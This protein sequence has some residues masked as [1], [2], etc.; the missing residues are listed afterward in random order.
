MLSLETHWRL[1][2]IDESILHLP[3]G[4]A[5]SHGG[6]VASRT[7]FHNIKTLAETL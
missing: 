6:E 4:H 2:K 3:A 5:F 7:C 1:E